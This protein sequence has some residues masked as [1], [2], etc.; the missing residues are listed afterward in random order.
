MRRSRP[1]H[2]HRH[3]L[4]R[5]H[6][7]RSKTAFAKPDNLRFININVA[8]F[9][10]YKHN[11]LPL[12]GRCPRRAGRAFCRCWMDYSRGGGLP[13]ARAQSYNQA[14]D[15]EVHRIYNLEHEPLLSQG[16]V[17]GMV[18]TLSGADDTVLS[19]AGSMPGD[20][21]KL[22]AH[23]QPQG[24]PHGIRLL[25]DGVRNR[26]RLGRQAG[27]ARARSLGDG[28]RRQLPDDAHGNRYHG[29]GRA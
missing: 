29:A 5:F 21:H 19:A 17:I 7:L 9:D 14:W 25:D 24:L 8:E 27:G 12:D 23:A 6:Q 10:A 1:R 2:R 28:R 22:W 11:A 18:N 20:L 26:R 15:A 13:P 4:Q 3:A 16:E